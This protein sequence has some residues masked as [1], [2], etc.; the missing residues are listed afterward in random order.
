MQ[1]RNSSG[2][3]RLAAKVRRPT[4]E[5]LHNSRA[6]AMQS[7]RK[8]GAASA[9]RQRMCHCWGESPAKIKEFTLLRSFHGNL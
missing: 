1:G 4:L 2:R 8:A 9:W 6:G 3:G 5:E 7:K